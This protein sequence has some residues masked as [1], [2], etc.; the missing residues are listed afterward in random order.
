MSEN[1]IQYAEGYNK[2][3]IDFTDI[4]KAINE[5]Q[6]TDD[7][8]CTFWVTVIKEDENVIETDKNLNLALVFDGNQIN[9]KAKDWYEVKELYKLL[10]DG[11]FNTIKQRIK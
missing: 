7:E 11:N 10:L 5:I 9:Y 4:E 8:H 1:Y 3:N 2:D 6:K